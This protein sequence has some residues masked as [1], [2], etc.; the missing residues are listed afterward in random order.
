MS[1]NIY[2][3]A[4]I[5]KRAHGVSDED[6]VD[7]I[8]L[9]AI[10]KNRSLGVTGCLWFNHTHFF[11]I[12]EGSKAAIDALFATIASDVRHSA[13]SLL[14]T[15]E[16][17]ERRFERFGLRAVDSDAARS[18]PS[19]IGALGPQKPQPPAERKKRWVALIKGDADDAQD[20]GSEGLSLAKLVRAVIDEMAGWSDATPA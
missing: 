20:T 18:M 3:L 14:L 8:V 10:A 12:L 1:T 6:I 7:G 17:P 16:A 11:Q 9:P 4:Y 2:Q 19:L 5:S 15:E 13:V